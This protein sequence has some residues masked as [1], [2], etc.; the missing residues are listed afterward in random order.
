MVEQEGEA[1]PGS[2]DQVAASD[3]TPQKP[4]DMGERGVAGDAPVAR[5][6]LAERF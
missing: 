3:E 6:D 4:A 5:I 2:G 1:A